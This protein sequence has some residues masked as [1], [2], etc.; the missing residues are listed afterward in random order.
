MII[1]DEHQ[2]TIRKSPLFEGLVQKDFLL[3]IKNSKLCSLVADEVLFRQHQPALDFFFLISGNI[4]LSLL[5]FDG[6]EKVIEIITDRQ[7]F[8]EAIMFQNIPNF[9][10]SAVALKESHLLRIN[11]KVYSKILANSPSTCI[12]VIT[13]LSL[14][15]HWSVRELDRLS[16][17]NATYRLVSYLLENIADHVVEPTTIDLSIAKHIIASRISVTPETL[18]RTLKRLSQQG[19]LEVHDK[20]IILLNPVELRHIISI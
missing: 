15:L 3:V 17:H 6:A 11:A 7:S 8:A 10:V 20:H 14:R 9:P 18:S 2:K 12:K 4:K 13:A 19:L 16:L 5:S 1:S